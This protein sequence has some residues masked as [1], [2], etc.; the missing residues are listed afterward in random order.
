MRTMQYYFFFNLFLIGGQLLYNVVSIS[1]IQ[2]H[3][4]AISIHIP[5]PLRPPSHPS[6]PT[7]LV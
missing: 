1:A 6:H 4:S 5:L 7:P 3:E 2:E